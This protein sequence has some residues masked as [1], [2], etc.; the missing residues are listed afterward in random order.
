MKITNSSQSYTIDE[1]EV[2]TSRLEHNDICNDIAA[3]HVP[4]E[5][6]DAERYAS[7]VETDFARVLEY[8]C[9]RMPAFGTF[10]D[11]DRLCAEALSA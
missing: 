7:D 1:N 2:V 9:D 10:A 5:D 8:A 3:S 4:D 6:E 11:F